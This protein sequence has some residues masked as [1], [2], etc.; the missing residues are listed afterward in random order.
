MSK[1][2]TSVIS[3]A[4]VIAASSAVASVGAK[5]EISPEYNV[6]DEVLSG[7]D[8]ILEKKV[9]KD[10]LNDA[11]GH[12]VSTLSVDDKTLFEV[13]LSEYADG[14]NGTDVAASYDSTILGNNCVA[15]STCYSNCYANCH[16]AC[17]GS[18]GWR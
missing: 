5:V 17:H 4:M 18:R 9:A 6:S 8:I 3:T 14:D 7:L 1:M 10:A 15:S 16:S 2:E 13:Y 11:F 12:I